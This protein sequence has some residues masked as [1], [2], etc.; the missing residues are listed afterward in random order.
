[1]WGITYP[2]SRGGESKFP[3]F[4]YSDVLCNLC[5]VCEVLEVFRIVF[6]N[7]FPVTA[8]TQLQTVFP[9]G[10]SAFIH[11]CKCLSAPTHFEN[12]FANGNCAL[13]HSCKL[14]LSLHRIIYFCFVSTTYA[15]TA[16]RTVCLFEKQIQS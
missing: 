9:N 5:F 14:V 1:M 15:C 6:C 2:P 7:V 13:L 11:S 16:L 4:S 12:K 3:G 8:P 10:T